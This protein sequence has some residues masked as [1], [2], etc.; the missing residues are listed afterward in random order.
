MSSQLEVMSAKLKS[1]TDQMSPGTL[2][3]FIAVLAV[4]ST[5][6]A[7]AVVFWILRTVSKLLVRV[8]LGGGGGA[9]KGR[10]ER[11]TVV[12]EVAG[13][14]WMNAAGITHPEKA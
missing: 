13:S 4:V 6:V 9:E 7:F 14:A 2:D 12:A 11:S 3:T 5:S 1:L 8:V 10:E